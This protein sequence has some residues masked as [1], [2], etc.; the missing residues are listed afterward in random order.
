[1]D[2]YCQAQETY[3]HVFN[4][5]T[6]FSSRNRGTIHTILWQ[7]RHI[8][9]I[10]IIWII[11]DIFLKIFTY[12]TKIIVKEI[13]YCFGVIVSTDQ[14]SN[15]RNTELMISVRN[16]AKMCHVLVPWQAAGFSLIRSIH[17]TEYRVRFITIVFLVM[18]KNSGD[19]TMSYTWNG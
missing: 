9:F 19:C 12:C 1:M 15:Q 2:Q 18:K 6:N 10:W 4:N 17:R 16:I 14:C 5:I 7:T 13:G 8:W 3:V 11:L